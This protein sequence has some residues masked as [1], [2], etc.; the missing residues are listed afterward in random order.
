MLR[1]PGLWYVSVRKRHSGGPPAPISHQEAVGLPR[2]TLVHA[3]DDRALLSSPARFKET[4][5]F[6]IA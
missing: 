6:K 4:R 5:W 2:S 3:L 1:G